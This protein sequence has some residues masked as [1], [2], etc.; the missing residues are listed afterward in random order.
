MT[1]S[2]SSQLDPLDPLDP[3]PYQAGE[4]QIYAHLARKMDGDCIKKMVGD[5]IINHY[6]PSLSILNHHYKHERVIIDN[7]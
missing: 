5:V 3:A 2:K 1:P 6:Q 4:E 7:G